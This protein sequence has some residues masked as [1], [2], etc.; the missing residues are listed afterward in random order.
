MLCIA[1][2][3]PSCNV[4][5]YICP[6][7]RLSATF[8]YCIKTKRVN[9]SSYFSPS[10][11]YTILVF[12]F[13]TLWQY[14]NGDPLTGASNG[15]LDVSL[16]CQFATWTFRYHL[17]RFATWTFLHLDVSYLWTFLYQDVS[18]PSWTFRQLSQSL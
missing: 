14:S 9:I 7:V 12:P 4:C 11:S 6:S 10:D 3:M 15:L 18:L 16:L 13:Q 8:V 5:L 2:P 17:R 1:R